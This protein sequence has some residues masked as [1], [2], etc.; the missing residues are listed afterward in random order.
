[1][2]EIF[3]PMPHFVKDFETHKNFSSQHLNALKYIE[4]LFYM[5]NLE[6]KKLQFNAKIACPN[7]SERLKAF[8]ASLPFKLTNDQQNAIKE[9]QS[10]LTSPIACKRLIIGDVGCGK[11]MVILASM[12]L[13]YPN[14][15][16]LMAPTSILAK[17]LYNEALKF[18]PLILKWN[19]CLAGA[20]RSDPIICL[21]QSRMW[22]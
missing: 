5:K 9:I 2:L 13:A 17:Q 11:T 16:L 12:V 22:L 15:T 10:D 21:K 6:R 1:M 14:K 18:Y 3:F 19:Y 20:T 7:N 4:M 8:I